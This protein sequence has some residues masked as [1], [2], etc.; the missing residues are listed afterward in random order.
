MSPIWLTQRWIKVSL[1]RD[2]E[3]VKV[4]LGQCRYCPEPNMGEGAVWDRCFRH[5]V[6]YLLRKAGLAK[7]KLPPWEAEKREKITVYLRTRFDAVLAGEELLDHD[8]ALVAAFEVRENFGISWGGAKGVVQTAKVIQ[9]VER[10]A[11]KRRPNV[12]M[13]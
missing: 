10:M 2:R 13:G 11:L 3:K 1:Q 7:G 6:Q 5:G 9:V 12:E 8:K 4:A